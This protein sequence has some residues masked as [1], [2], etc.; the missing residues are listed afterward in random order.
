MVAQYAA[1]PDNNIRRERKMKTIVKG[2]LMGIALSFIAAFAAF[3]SESVAVSGNSITY[4][5]DV[6]GCGSAK[7]VNLYVLMNGAQVDVRG[8]QASN[9][10]PRTNHL[11]NKQFIDMSV[12]IG[13]NTKNK[14][15]PSWYTKS[16]SGTRTTSS[17]CSSISYS[18]TLSGGRLIATVVIVNPIKAV[19]GICFVKQSTSGKDTYFD[20]IAGGEKDISEAVSKARG[21][22]I[23]NS[24][25]T[26]AE[27]EA[28][29]KQAEEEAKKK[30]EEE[31]KRKAEEEAKRKAEEEAKRQAE[32][33]A[34]RKAEEEAKRQAEEEA[35]RKAEEEA[36]RKA[37]EE[38]K[39]KAE[40][41]SKQAE[42]AKKAEEK[43]KKENAISNIKTRIKDCGSGSSKIKDTEIP[44]R[45][46][47][48]LALALGDLF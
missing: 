5:I 12:A 35:R 20:K 41:E 26:Q 15:N 29:K 16:S 38:A 3:A 30:A 19:T 40:E 8:S 44:C 10:T 28:A 22:Y 11:L 48:Q 39:R 7:A 18:Y 2:L 32:E 46:L 33:E 27:I 21:E 6:T 25:P 1:P 13:N 34:K 42:E 36:R 17:F 14:A 23:V 4:K 47:K 31:A 24:G 45:K 37:E 43:A 9:Y